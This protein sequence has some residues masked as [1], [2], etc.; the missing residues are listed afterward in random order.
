MYYVAFKKD[1]ILS[2]V[3]GKAESCD[4]TPWD[5]LLREVQEE[6]GVTNVTMIDGSYYEQGTNYYHIATTQL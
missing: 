4:C 3:G 5:F 2:A 6:T 1:G